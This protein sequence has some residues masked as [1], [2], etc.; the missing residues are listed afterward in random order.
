M[1]L[2]R[3]R[4]ATA[5]AEQ[6][7]MDTG[8]EAPA[9]AAEGLVVVGVRVSEAQGVEALEEVD[10]AAEDRVLEVR[11]V[12]APVAEVPATARAAGDGVAARR[13]LTCGPGLAAAAARHLFL[14][15]WPASLLAAGAS[16]PKK[17]SS[18][19]LAR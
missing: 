15:W 14:E 19:F 9:Q 2:P 16:R 7:W 1:L 3:G 12:R 5:P 10:Q 8:W 18:R 11:E 13:Q 6:D 4:K 17:N